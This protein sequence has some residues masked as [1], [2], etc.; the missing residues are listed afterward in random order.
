MN[1]ISK[2]SLQVGILGGALLLGCASAKA[3]TYTEN[4]GENDPAGT[5][6]GP[7]NGAP[8]SV[9][10]VADGYVGGHDTLA[11]ALSNNGANQL[12]VGDVLIYEAANPTVLSDVLR[13]EDYGVGYVYVYSAQDDGPSKLA[14]TGMPTAFQANTVSFIEQFN[15]S[16]Y[17]L[18]NYTPTANQPGYSSYN[19]PNA[20]TSGYTYSFT[21]D[22]VLVPEPGVMT[23]GL[24]GMGLVWLASLTKWR[25]RA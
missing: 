7:G 18:F 25:A 17:G 15:G 11:Y 19:D 10:V 2:L 6:T 3:V 5:Q 8:M 21:S 20:T 23:L 12:I 9:G 13:F 14:D 24:L 16:A 4:L 22:E 1:Q